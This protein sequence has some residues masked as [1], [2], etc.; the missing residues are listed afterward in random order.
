MQTTAKLICGPAQFMA[1]IA[2]ESVDLIVTSPPYPMV[3]MWDEIFARQ[4]GRIGE[5]LSSGNGQAA[6][7]LMHELL[8]AVWLE[9]NRVMKPGGIACI[10][11]GDATRTLDGDFQLYSNHSRILSSFLGQGFCGFARYTLAQTD[12]RPQQIYGVWDAARRGVCDLR[13]RVHSRV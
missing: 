12:Q 11:I 9:C 8:D 6:F 2:D 5:Q 4:D 1:E 13:A 10:N 3:E 7:A